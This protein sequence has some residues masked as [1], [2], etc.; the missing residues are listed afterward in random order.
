MAKLIEISELR[1]FPPDIK[2]VSVSVSKPTEEQR[3]AIVDKAIR[4]SEENN[5]FCGSGGRF[6]DD[7]RNVVTVA[8]AFEHLL[9]ARAGAKE[10][11][12]GPIEKPLRPLT[13]IEKA[14]FGV[15]IF[16]KNGVVTEEFARKVAEEINSL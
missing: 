8:H 12:V 9:V 11:I 4:V 15:T 5:K 10:A 2:A 14:R 6:K 7:G 13:R 3:R 16:D 1:H